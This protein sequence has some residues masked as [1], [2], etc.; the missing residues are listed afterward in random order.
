MSTE[1]NSLSTD[2]LVREYLQSRGLTKTL[3]ALESECA[4]VSAIPTNTTKS[5]LVSSFL[6][7]NSQ[8]LLFLT[9]NN[10]DGSQYSREYRLFSRWTTASLDLIK[11]YLQALSFVL[12]THSYIILVRREL[13]E[14]ARNFF[15]EFKDTVSFTF[16][17]ELEYLALLQSKQQLID[18][19]FLSS[20][21]FLKMTTTSKFSVSFTHLAFTL[22]AAF[23][24]ENE[25]V[26]LAAIFNESVDMKMVENE[27]HYEQVV[28]ISALLHL[29]EY[30]LSRGKVWN[31]AKI[32][33]GVPGSGKQL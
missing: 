1:G 21:P 30:T 2:L 9:M 8:E 22:L 10:S 5:A 25:L 4:A 13:T 3:E 19:S 6:P 14:Q 16:T 15:N 18:A 33:L 26:L 11:P 28:D 24:D 23:L 17:E 20:N 7:V 29:P 12:F 27:L 31:N 32:V